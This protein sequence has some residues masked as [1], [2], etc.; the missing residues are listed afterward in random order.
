LPPD[1]TAAAVARSAAA[2]WARSAGWADPQAFDLL[3][4]VSELAANAVRHGGPPIGLTL[5]PDGPGVRVVVTDHGHGHDPRPRHATVTAGDGRGLAM[6]DRLSR[7]TGW[8]RFADRLEVWAIV[9]PGD[10]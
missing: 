5:T 3:L 4:V 8:Q 1:T 9:D 7:A 2:G 10:A 6:V